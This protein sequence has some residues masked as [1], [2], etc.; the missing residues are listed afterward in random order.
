MAKVKALEGPKIEGSTPPT[1]EAGTKTE[2]ETETETET[3]ESEGELDIQTS[4]GELSVD[5]S[6]YSPETYVPAEVT[7]E[8]EGASGR[9]TLAAEW[10]DENGD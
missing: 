1:E 5:E 6:G 10:Y 8:G 4:P 9:I 7:N 3:A 2:T